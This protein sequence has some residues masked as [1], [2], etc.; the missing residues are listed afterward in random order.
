MRPPQTYGVPPVARLLGIKPWWEVKEMQASV[1]RMN[2]ALM[3]PLETGL[4]KFRKELL[5]QA[6]LR[7]RLEKFDA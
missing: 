4:E 3:E 6:D 1:A 2:T 5:R 7:A